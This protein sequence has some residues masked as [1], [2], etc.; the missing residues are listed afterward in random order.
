MK[1]PQ[2]LPNMIV[3][4]RDQS[5]CDQ[6]GLNELGRIRDTL[7]PPSSATLHTYSLLWVHES[8]ET[9]GEILKEILFLFSK[10]KAGA[11]V[12]IAVF[13]AHLL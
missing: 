9:P 12:G 6:D 1:F 3:A 13:A 7:E 10:N 4:W 5:L 8:R 2:D 11:E